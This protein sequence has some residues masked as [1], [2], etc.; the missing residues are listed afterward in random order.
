[1]RAGERLGGAV[2]ELS[3]MIE[4]VEKA[5]PWD[6]VKSATLAARAARDALAIAADEIQALGE[7][8]ERV[9]RGEKR[10]V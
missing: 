9:E 2:R 6:A 3:A 10:D 7:R 4:R 5:A 8:V 1:M